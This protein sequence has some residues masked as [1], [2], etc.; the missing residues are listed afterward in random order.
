MQ[1][2]CTGAH[3]TQPRNTSRTTNSSWSV[4]W[5]VLLAADVIAASSSP[6]EYQPS[7]FASA[8]RMIAC[9]CVYRSAATAPRAPSSFSTCETAGSLKSSPSVPRM[10]TWHAVPRESHSGARWGAIGTHGCG[11]CGCGTCGCG[12]TFAGACHALRSTSCT[13]DSPRTA[14]SRCGEATA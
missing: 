2:Y 6:L 1:P 12:L 13:V 3:A 4:G 9:V 5:R 8:E 7:L 11:T 14:W 10:L